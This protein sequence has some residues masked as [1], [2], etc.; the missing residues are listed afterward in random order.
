M[1][2]VEMAK[3]VGKE[4]GDLSEA[5]HHFIEKLCQEH[6]TKLIFVKWVDQRKSKTKKQARRILVVSSFIMFIVKKSTGSQVV[7]RIPKKKARFPGE[8][9][10][11]IHKQFHFLDLR[12]IT[13][14]RKNAMELQFSRVPESFSF[15]T[16]FVGEYIR[17]IR[18]AIRLFTNGFP[19]ER[20]PGLFGVEERDLLPLERCDDYG[21]A[22]GFLHTFSAFCCFYKQPISREVRRYVADLHEAGVVE[23]SLH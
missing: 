19:K 14:T 10:L 16:Q 11:K 22:H 15:M 4:E 23:F 2:V 20:L 7:T 8:I 18:T 21:P 5:E 3:N 9:R 12:S 6:Q 17:G 13:C 1:G